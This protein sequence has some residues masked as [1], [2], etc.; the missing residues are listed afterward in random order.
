M[1]RQARCERARISAIDGAPPGR[2]ASLRFKAGS[3]G[4]LPGFFVLGYSSLVLFENENHQRDDCAQRNDG[5][6]IHVIHLPS[7]KLSR[8]SEAPRNGFYHQGNKETPSLDELPASFEKASW[9]V[10]KRA[11]SVGIWVP[12]E[13]GMSSGS[14]YV[15]TLNRCWGSFRQ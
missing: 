10:K 6:T 4:K 12:T 8:P 14:S 3:G 13:L 1:L 11:S 2:A 9:R 15:I 7:G 5:L